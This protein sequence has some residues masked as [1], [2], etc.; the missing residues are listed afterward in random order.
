MDI[1]LSGVDPVHWAETR[2]RVEILRQWCA[3]PRHT[4]ADGEAAAAR[5]GVSAKHFARLVTAWR[6]HGDA[7]RISG[8]PA[9]RGDRRMFRT[10][11]DSTVEAVTTAIERLG[12]RA[13]SGDIEREAARLC[14]LADVPP[15][16]TGM[17]HNLLMRARQLA[18]GSPTRGDSDGTSPPALRGRD[19]ERDEGRRVLI[20]R[21]SIR[22]PIQCGDDVHFEPD[23]LLAVRADGSAIIG[24]RLVT[25][26]DLETDAQALIFE[27]LASRGELHIGG[28][29]IARELADG[30]RLFRGSEPLGPQGLVIS[31]TSRLLSNLLGSYID[32]VPIRH[33]RRPSSAIK[34][35]EPL[36]L[37]DGERA[38]RLAIEGFNRARS[39]I[40]ASPA[41]EDLAD[42]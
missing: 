22:L 28:L 5:M 36:T 2:R 1:D 13:R 38:V 16:S 18:P 23:L 4:K 9:R 3:V 25:K 31:G 33:N 17:F 20:G 37:D 19:G 35:I 6:K 29:T 11:S 27:I 26:N 12:P 32:S 8:H 21:V 24:H 39:P 34:L 41:R 42:A 40:G 10:L 7:V 30:V 14:A 15:P